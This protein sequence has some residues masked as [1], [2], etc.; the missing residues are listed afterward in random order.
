MCNRC[1]ILVEDFMALVELEAH[2][3]AMRK[4]LD[5]LTASGVEIPEG[6]LSTMKRLIAEHFK[7]VQD[8]RAQMVATAHMWC[9]GQRDT[10]E[11]ER[12]ISAILP[13]FPSQVNWD[14][15]LMVGAIDDLHAAVTPNVPVAEA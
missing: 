11:A 3:N 12:L 5:Y 14:L 8:G 2:Q 1:N 7:C 6:D 13:G 4:A 10:K 9:A 15:D